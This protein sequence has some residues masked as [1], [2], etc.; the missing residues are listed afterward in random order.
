MLN[1]RT[2]PE[3]ITA[4]WADRVSGRNYASLLQVLIA[5]KLILCHELAVLG[6]VN[7][8]GYRRREIL[9]VILVVIA[10][11]VRSGNRRRASRRRRG[12]HTLRRALADG[13]E[14]V[15]RH[16]RRRAVS[17]LQAVHAIRVTHVDRCAFWPAAH[18]ISH[19][20]SVHGAEILPRAVQ[21]GH[22]AFLI[23]WRGGLVQIGDPGPTHASQFPTAKQAGHSF[24]SA[25]RVKT[26]VVIRTLKF[27]RK[28]EKNVRIVSRTGRTL[29]QYLPGK[30]KPQRAKVRNG[31]I[32]GVQLSPQKDSATRTMNGVRTF[33]HCLSRLRNFREYYASKKRLIE[34]PSRSRHNRTGN[35]HANGSIIVTPWCIL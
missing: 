3:D 5:I 7:L 6:D 17:A 18:Y 30:N 4:G 24:D 16:I 2:V 29:F 1:V 33:F 22:T 26:L 27:Q 20:F 15:P 14:H 25:G 34:L 12:L 9:V 21:R 23:R 32:V 11:K 10:T 28:K 19:A 8:S 31:H 13:L 35:I